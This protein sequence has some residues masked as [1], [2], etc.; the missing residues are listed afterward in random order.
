M[1]P[2]IIFTAITCTLHVTY[3]PNPLLTARFLQH[4]QHALQ[5]LVMATIRDEDRFQELH[6]DEDDS[7]N[8]DF[9]ES[10]SRSR[11]QAKNLYPMPRETPEI[12]ETTQV[13]RISCFVLEL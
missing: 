8:S 11:T 5:T 4:N 1:N 10:V 3:P 2:R 13:S 7:E 12:D 9:D 6:S